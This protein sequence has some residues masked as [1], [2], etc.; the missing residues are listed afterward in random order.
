MGVAA[1]MS[2]MNKPDIQVKILFFA[3]I[4]ERVK[5]ASATLTLT[6][7]TNVSGLKN[8]LS[9][10][11][12]ILDENLPNCLVSINQEFAF[13]QDLIPDQAEI[14]I[15]PPVSGGSSPLTYVKLTQNEL[16]ADELIAMVTTPTT[17][18]VCV[19]AGIVRAKTIRG[20]AHETTQLNYEAY[21][22]M[23]EAEMGKIA[24]EMRARWPEIEG[25]A[26]VQRLGDVSAG[27]STVLIACSAGHRDTGVFD[28][29][30]YG[31]D[32]LKE[33]VPIWKKEIGPDG[34]KW[35]EGEFHPAQN[36]RHP[37]TS[38]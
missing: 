10:K 24:E 22:P 36:D 17:G 18:A 8:V 33:I 28:A 5:T 7:G 1:G 32:R 9:E 34:E 14:A 3:T 19:F 29:A 27:V 30:R 20:E 31:I 13:D 26:M 21:V 11:Y 15:F 25:I 23:A 4:K 12:P 35:V 16:C 37:K 38:F 2:A 6:S